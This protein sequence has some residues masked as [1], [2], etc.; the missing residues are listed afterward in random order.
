MTTMPILFAA[1]VL[2]ILLPCILP[3]VPIVL[4]ASVSGTRKLRP[5]VTIAGMATSFVVF[6]VAAQSLLQRLDS[7]TDLVR[8][9]SYDVLFLFG[10]GFLITRRALRALLAAAGALP[11]FWSHGPTTVIIAAIASVA[12]VLLGSR[13]TAR[14]QQMGTHVQHEA[15]AELGHESL[16][17]AFIVGLTLGLVWVPCAGPALGFALTLVRDEPGPRAVAALTVY[18]LG[19]S[20]PLLLLG[21]GGQRLLGSARAVG[22]FG[23]RIKQ[24]AGVVLVLCALAFQSQL[25]LGLQTWLASRTGFGDLGAKL[26]QRL[27]GTAMAAPVVSHAA[28]SALSLP[29]LPKLGHAPELVGLGPW[30]NSPPLSSASLRGKVVLV[31]FWTYSCINCVRT[32]PHLRE[33]WSTYGKQPFVIV[34][35]HA[36]E[37]VCERSPPNVAA[38]IKKHGLAY[39]I[40]QD[41][42]FRTWKAFDNR[43]WPAKY[44]IDATGELRYTHFGEGAE[45]EMDLAIRSLLAESGQATPLATHAR[46]MTAGPSTGRISPETYVGTRGWFSF[47]NRAGPPDERRHRYTP[48]AHL[49]ENQ[50]ALTGDWQLVDGERQVLRSDTGEIRYRAL[51]GEVNLVLGIEPGSAPA[52][53]DV[54]VDGKPGRHLTIDRHDLYNL[55]SGPYGKHDVALQIHGP[56]V[57]AYALTFGG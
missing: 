51:A 25:F 1:G 9:A 50:F 28:R 49:A 5:L 39:P 30:Y 13:V 23:H 38:A 2:T 16:L 53:A 44:L 26:E 32:L 6:T 56:E 4:G 54:I 14:V 43:Y 19:A 57:A 7:L 20:T 22:R 40:A 24:S 18:A 8:V 46:A 15:S 33:L 37:F 11:F 48:P 47:A 3:V 45:E 10:I 36:P 12:A 17:A 35:V 52:S 27:V 55:F 42:D 21:Y 41:N 34:G 31:D 29:R